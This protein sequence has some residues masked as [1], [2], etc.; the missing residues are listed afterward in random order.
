MHV[1]IYVPYPVESSYTYRA[2]DNLDVAPGTRVTVNFA[3]R[4]TTGYVVDAGA[5]PVGTYEIKDV[6]DVIDDEPVFD[7]RLVELA[8]ITSE[9][10]LSSMGEV[11]AMAL[12]SGKRQ[13]HRYRL[14][15]EPCP[16]NK[17][18]VLNK[19]QARVYRDIIENL[20]EP[21]GHLIY[22]I[23]GPRARL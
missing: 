11:L 21:R 23:T 8:R 20:N 12:P 6:I 18:I 19:E 22:G 17:D 7:E 2:P 4:V 15:F 14:P 13:T 5:D 3:G 9:T 16:Q 10:Y 1:N